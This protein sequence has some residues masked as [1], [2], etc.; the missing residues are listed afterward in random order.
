MK[1]LKTLALTA[2]MMVSTGLAAQAEM[3]LRIGT[4]GAYKPFNFLDSAKQ[5]QGF[6]IDIAKALCAEMK[7]KCTFVTQDWDGII[8]ALKAK[9]YDAI[10]ASMSINE[11]RKKHVA[12]TDKYYSSP[13]AFVASK[14]SSLTAV[15]KDTMKGKTLGAQQGTVMARYLEENFPADSV[16]VYKTQEQAN[17]DL[18]AG[19]LDAVVYEKFVG[20]AWLQ[21]KA[22][23]CCKFVGEDITDQ[24]YVGTGV[25]IALRK[26]DTE[27]VKKFNAAIKA[28]RE[29]GTYAKI[30]AKYF[31]FDIH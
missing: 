23:A 22:G 5:L 6:D 13:M 29:N 3:T 25:G 24:K 18:A 16:K 8:P 12:F 7:A 1:T 31:P 4:E 20:Y 17:L 14:K 30:N 27:L 11:K 19:R 15:N 26:K 28:I 9:K 21:E 2:A 10:I